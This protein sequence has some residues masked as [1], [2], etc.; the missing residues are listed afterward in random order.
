M[1]HRTKGEINYEWENYH[2]G[3][4]AC[5]LVLKKDASRTEEG[6]VESN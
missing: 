6:R 3:E 4:K 1:E 5:E 2:Y